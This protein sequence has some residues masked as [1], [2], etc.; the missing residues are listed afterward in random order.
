MQPF[1][2]SAACL[3]F[4]LTVGQTLAQP[5]G[6]VA[7]WD[8]D[9]GKGAWITDSSGNK[10]RG[11]L[12]GAR[13]VEVGEGHALRF[14]GVDDYVDCGAGQ[15]LDL[16]GPLTLEAWVHPDAPPRGE[17]GILGKFFESYAISFYRGSAWFYISGGGNGVIAGMT[18]G[19]WQHVV[20]VFDGKS[21]SLYINGVRAATRESL[22][23]QTAAGQNFLLGCIVGDLSNI[24]KALR[25]TA[26]YAGMIDSVRVYNRPLT[27][28]EIID[29]YNAE[30]VEKECEPIDLSKI[31]QLVVTPYLYPH[32]N[33]IVAEVDYGWLQPRPK[34]ADVHVSLARVT[35]GQDVVWNRHSPRPPDAHGRV[36]EFEF[37]MEEPGQGEYELTA[38]FGKY[39]A[40]TRFELPLP[41]AELPPAD[42]HVVASLPAP[43]QP[44]KFGLKVGRQGGMTVTIGRESFAVEST[45]SYPHGG[46]NGLL[47]APRE[48][49]SP[50]REWKVRVTKRKGITRA[51]RAEG[52]FYSLDR[53]IRLTESRIEVEDTFTNKTDDVLGIILSNHINLRE[54][55]DANPILHGNPTV[56]AGRVDIGLGLI[57]LDDVYFLQLQNRVVD[58]LAELHDAHFG[59]AAGASYTVKWAIYPTASASYYDFINQVRRD[60]QLNGHVRG[61]LTLSTGWNP[62]DDEEVRNKS[63]GYMCQCLLTRVLSNPTISLEGWEFIDHPEVADRIRQ[64]LQSTREQWPDLQ[65]GIHVAHSLYA[66]NNPERFGDSKAIAADGSQ[67]MYGPN[68]MEYYGKYFSKELVDDNWRWW[69][70]YPTLENSF[71]KTMLKAADQLIHELGANFMWADGYLEGYVREG[72]TYDHFDGHSVTIDPETKLV[73]RQKANVTL[74]ALPVLKAVA[75]KFAEAGGTLVSNGKPGPPSYWKEKT[76]NS[77][78]TAGGDQTPVSA[79]HLGRTVTPL[80]NP[81]VLHNERDIYRDVLTKLDLGALYFYYGETDHRPGGHNYITRESIVTHMYP[82]TFDRIEPGVVTGLKKIVTNKSGVYGWHESRELHQVYLSDAR[83]RIVPNRFTTAVDAQSVRTELNLEPD[84]SAVVAKIPVSL[85]SARPVNIRVK[86]YGEAGLSLVA[87]GKGRVE[88]VVSAG[89]LPIAAGQMFRLTVGPSVAKVAAAKQE[90]RFS[91]DLDGVTPIELTP[92]AGKREGQQKVGLKPGLMWRP[93][94]AAALGHVERDPRQAGVSQ[95]RVLRAAPI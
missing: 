47:V 39:E 18:V 21:M 91:A 13:W 15:S 1:I 72:Y 93:D 63:L 52:N 11:K 65:V 4:L 82:F 68:T 57:A 43:V 61:G 28:R 12:H 8:L 88:F 40:S 2:R 46:E 71:G 83:G 20:G 73:T 70:F 81:T 24:D 51:V 64:T 69:I 50:E 92:V 44:P 41:A 38:S 29:H 90:V 36:V 37:D 66:M 26:F 31:G 75:R 9:E 58:G 85:N 60:E 56:F 95:A 94:L 5:E 35:G 17:P 59:L 32:E 48:E 67:V 14:D 62:P 42:Q 55:S 77:N 7:A 45:F 30:A 34:A 53:Q 22:H 6:L 79:M 86:S 3:L 23:K 19:K 54:L 16:R 25:N 33:K 84:E 49:L 76:V 74:V 89:E 87:S 80:G 27:D 10:N 78:E